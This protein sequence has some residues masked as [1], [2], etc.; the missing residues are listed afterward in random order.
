M[1]NINYVIYSHTD[2]LDILKIQ[3]E[4]SKSFNK[5]LIINDTDSISDIIHE[6]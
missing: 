4:F 6:F 2:Y 1:E 5:T 3:I